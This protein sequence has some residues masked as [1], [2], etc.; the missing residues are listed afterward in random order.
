MEKSRGADDRVDQMSHAL[1]RLCAL[2]S[3]PE[4]SPPMAL[5]PERRPGMDGVI[6][7]SGILRRRK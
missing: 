4:Y 5:P 1:N 6:G 3:L 7:W 2:V